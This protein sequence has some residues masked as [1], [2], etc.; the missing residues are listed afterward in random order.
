MPV[1]VTNAKN[2]M[3]YGITKSLGQRHIRVYTSDFLTGSM[4]FASRYSSGSF[5]Y[6][7]PFKKQ[8]EFVETLIE[9]IKLHHCN[10]LIPVS[11]ETYLIAKHKQRF[12]QHTNVVIPDYDQILMAHNKDRWGALAAK[13]AIPCPK[14]LEVVDVRQGGKGLSFPVLIKPKQGGGGWGIIQVDSQQDLDTIIN[15]EDYC[16]RPWNRFFIQ[17][18]IEGQTHCVAMLFRQGEYRAKVGYRQLRSYPIKCGQATL[19]VSVG[20]KAAEDSLQRLLEELKWHGVCQADFIID[21]KSGIPYLIDI[22]PRFW[23]SLAQSIACGVDFPYLVYQIGATGDVASQASFR[24]GV[25]T[26]WVGGDLAAFVPLLREADNKLSF[27]REYFWPAHR[28]CHYDD[29]SLSDPLPFM[30]WMTDAVY[31][32]VKKRGAQ[33][34][35]HESLEGIWE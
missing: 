22:N 1:I 28:A 24:T 21:K 26:R 13:L 32:S 3:A 5:L 35:T 8:D 18:K 14:S 20:N 25:V 4:T 7:S 30:Y 11:E 27:I 29:L 19:R 15:R 17:E 31:R 2:R 12:L 34:R 9:K 6:P 16:G 10:V 33:S 23:G